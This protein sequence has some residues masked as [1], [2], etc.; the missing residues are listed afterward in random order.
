VPGGAAAGAL[1]AAS[2]EPHAPCARAEDLATRATEGTT[3]LSDPAVLVELGRV[4]GMLADPAGVQRLQ[5]ALDRTTDPEAWG[6]IVLELAQRLILKGAVTEAVTLTSTGAAASTSFSSAVTATMFAEG[7]S[8]AERQIEA[9][10]S[11]SARHG[12]VRATRCAGVS[13]ARC[14]TGWGGCRRREM[15]SVPRAAASASPADCAR[16]SRKV[17]A[18]VAPYRRRRSFVAGP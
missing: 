9:G 13:R 18:R 1:Q 4:E 3:L 2:S 5:L 11:D 8:E 6:R 16:S 12:S 10:L 7:Y 14:T 17:T 15:M